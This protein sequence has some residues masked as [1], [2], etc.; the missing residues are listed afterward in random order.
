TGPIHYDREN[1]TLKGEGGRVPEANLKN[2]YLEY[3]Q[4]T[5]EV[6]AKIFSNFV[7]SWFT[8]LKGLP[9]EF[10]D[11][12][13]DLLPAIR[14]R[15]SIELNLLKARAD[16]GKAGEWPY[17]VVGEHLSLS[18]VYDLPE[19]MISIQQPHLDDWGVSFPEALQVAME[20]LAGMS[21]H[22]FEQPGPGVWQSPWR[23]NHDA[24][25]LALLPL[26]LAHQVKGDL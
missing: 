1:F 10:E 6:R 26:L 3:C 23:D 2:I 11:A 18:L 25:R 20:N 21:G 5:P 8:P 14:A 15:A 12:R 9:E 4:S 7:R 17:A 24:A 19:A 22:R 16:G 13:H